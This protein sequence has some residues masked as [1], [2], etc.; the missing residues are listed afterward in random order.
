MNLLENSWPFWDLILNFVRQ[1]QR[2]HYLGLLLPQYQR[3]LLLSTLPH[4]LE[5][6]GFFHSDWWEHEL[7]LALCKYGDCS[8]MLP[9]D[10]SNFLTWM[11]LFL[12]RGRFKGELLQIL[13]LSL[14][15][16]LFSLVFCAEDSRLPVSSNNADCQVPEFTF[17]A[18][19]AEES[20]Q[21]K[22]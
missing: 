6:Q 17:S 14:C 2:S 19:R 8:F 21:A 16:V 7:F 4:A 10:P 13:K 15:A 11:N 1:D 3:D 9:P 12:L 20:Y 5:L 22:S 18:L